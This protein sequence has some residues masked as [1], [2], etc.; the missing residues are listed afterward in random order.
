[1]EN[2][3]V[4]IIVTQHE[5]LDGSVSYFIKIDGKQVGGEIYN[6]HEAQI[7]AIGLSSQLGGEYNGEIHETNEMFV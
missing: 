6:K 3:K 7:Q 5:W 1:M 4:K 2:K